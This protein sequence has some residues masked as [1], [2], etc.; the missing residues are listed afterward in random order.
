MHFR[1]A[2]QASD[3]AE[4]H[5][6]VY[7]H[8][9]AQSLLGGKHRSKAKRQHRG[10]TKAFA[11]DPG[12][13]PGRALIEVLSSRKIADNHG[14]IAARISGHRGAMDTAEIFDH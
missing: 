14:K 3:F 8:G 11:Y 4:K 7:A 12:M 9:P 6:P 1:F 13:I 2:A 10:E 5:A